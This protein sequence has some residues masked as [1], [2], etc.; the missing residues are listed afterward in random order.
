[1]IFDK[2]N[3]S[4]TKRQNSFRYFNIDSQLFLG[5]SVKKENYLLTAQPE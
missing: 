4:L 5:K 2:S 3:V 1:M